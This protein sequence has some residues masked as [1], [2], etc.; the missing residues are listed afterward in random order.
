MPPPT[1]F[2]RW[3]SDTVWEFRD[4]HRGRDLNHVPVHR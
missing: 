1:A 4:R 3:E 2:T